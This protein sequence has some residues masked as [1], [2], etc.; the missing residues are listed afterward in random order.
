MNLNTKSNIVSG[1]LYSEIKRRQKAHNRYNIMTWEPQHFDDFPGV[2]VTYFDKDYISNVIG[3][4]QL[5]DLD[6]R[7]ILTIVAQTGSGKTTWIFK[8]LIPWLLE[9][10]SDQKILYLCSRISLADQ[11]KHIAMKD[12]LNGEIYAGDCCVKDKANYFS[13]N[14][15][16]NEYDFGMLHIMTYQSY[17]AKHH[18]IN[19]KNYAFVIYD[20][21][22]FFLNESTFNPFT[23][24]ILLML[25]EHF[26]S[27][28]KIIL[29]ATPQYSLD[30]LWN[31][32]Y[33]S[34]DYQCLKPSMQIFYAQEDYS[35]VRAKFFA[36]M[37][38]IIE[39]IEVRSKESWLIFVKSKKIGK[40]LEETLS[41]K[42]IDCKL[43][44]A[45][46]DKDDED[47]QNLIANEKLPK[48]VLITTRLLDVGVNI[49]NT[50][51]NI[52][53]SDLE[54]SE[55]KQM[56]G[57]KRVKENETVNVYFYT[58]SIQELS[59]RSN[60]IKQKIAEVN[61]KLY[62]IENNEF[63]E[64]LEHPF[65]YHG[66]QVEMNSLCL[67]KLKFESHH[68]DQLIH[69]LEKYDDFLEQ[70]TA[71]AMYLLDEFDGILYDENDLLVTNPLDKLSDLFAEYE[72]QEMSK[73]EFVDFS[74]K[75]VGITGDPR[76]RAREK[77]PAKN[78]INPAL[79][80]YGYVVQSSGQPPK[81]TLI[82]KAGE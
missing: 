40:D 65:F 50:H 24:S 48:R 35:Y 44:T 70:T 73:E 59:K 47:Y 71:Y 26:R 4:N 21:A 60:S 61:K 39:E 74:G 20:E 41:N 54:L 72:N 62:A 53:V 64:Q 37:E 7:T 82:K 8:T 5:W 51:M 19:P 34:V 42:G 2:T 30:V 78:S 27:T 77:N 6:F 15:L 14:G 58:P 33:A 29:T 3:K 67:K 10:K 28:R 31:K 1:D 69:Y 25:C 9:H 32:I 18:K 43:I 63:I 80:K 81:Y 38:S 36:E 76:T 55:I 57:R 56:I 75:I 13:A 66:T 16:Q 49:K 52:V 23:E 11:I 22:H 46:T 12:E 45:D 79:D 17:H 68:Y